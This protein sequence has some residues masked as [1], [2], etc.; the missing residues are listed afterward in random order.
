MCLQRY[1]PNLHLYM[2]DLDPSMDTIARQYF[3]FKCNTRSVS[4]V[5]DGLDVIEQLSKG[6]SSKCTSSGSSS[7]VVDTTTT[8]SAAS[9]TTPTTIPSELLSQSQLDFIFIDADSND[10]TLG[11]SAPPAAFLTLSALVK[12]YSILKP[13]GGIY[14]NIVARNKIMLAELIV[15]L[16][17][18]FNLI[19]QTP[20][21]TSSD[22]KF[23]LN[24]TGKSAEIAHYKAEIC[25]IQ[26]ELGITTTAG[27]K[28]MFF[29]T[30]MMYVC[31]FF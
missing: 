28:L 12:T 2:C 6:S 24:Q 14:I 31:V 22:N 27:K 3:G 17:A 16:A 29:A 11:I 15:K 23:G 18:L 4:F 7:G 30:M 5:A 9:T 8:V 13:G 1:L 10:T 26:A 21:T 20:T 25:A 19:L